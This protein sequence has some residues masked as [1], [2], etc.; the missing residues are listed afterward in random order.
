VVITATTLVG[1]EGEPM[2]DF[3]PAMR[4][5]PNKEVMLFFKN[6]AAKNVAAVKYCDTSGACIDE[7]LNNAALKPFLIGKDIVGRRLGHFSGYVVAFEG[8]G[9]D[10]SIGLLRKSGYMVASGED[11]TD[12]MDDNGGRKHGRTE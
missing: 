7:S 3:Q 11:I 2:V 6:K 9:I 12:M 1:P 5:Q 4:F 10:I 8:L